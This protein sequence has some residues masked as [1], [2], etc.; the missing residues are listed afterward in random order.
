[1]VHNFGSARV[2]ASVF[3]LV[4]PM[5]NR[6]ESPHT[7]WLLH[8]VLGV[9]LGFVYSYVD[10]SSWLAV[11]SKPSLVVDRV[12]LKLTEIHSRNRIVEEP[13]TSVVGQEEQRR[14]EV[15]QHQLN[16]DKPKK[17]RLISNKCTKNPTENTDGR[18]F[19]SLLD[20]WKIAIINSIGWTI[21]SASLNWVSKSAV[22]TS[23][24]NAETGCFA[25][26]VLKI[27]KW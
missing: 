18:K 5:S 9:G 11:E 2:G 27:N 21:S 25:N 12:L 23:A 13:S 14:H 16:G 10:L 7:A 6:T 4:L 19:G 22:G 15:R 3:S 26:E 1:M 24:G 8:I 17:C 20:V